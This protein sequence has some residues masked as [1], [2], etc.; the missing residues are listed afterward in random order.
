MSTP[1][2]KKRRWQLW[3]RDLGL[4]LLAVVAIQWWQTR[5]AAS[6]M[7]PPLAGRLLDGGLVSLESYRGRPL[8]VHFWATWCP[9]CRVEEGSIDDLARDY[10]VLTVAS[11]SGTAAEVAAYLKQQGL[12]FPV[13]LDESGD[14]GRRWG[15][16]G[17][18]ASFIVDPDGEI[19]HV[20]VGYTTGL[21][22]R[23][24]LWLAG[25]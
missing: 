21:G 16:R 6:G 13:L 9:V 1:T 10:P 12:R 19:A 23:V 11:N 3:L 18:P 25:L 17:V 15:V 8:L 22:L 14:A 4:L 5:D 7:A 20:A 2:P 24:R